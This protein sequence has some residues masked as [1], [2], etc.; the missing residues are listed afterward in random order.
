MTALSSS[1]APLDNDDVEPLGLSLLELEEEETTNHIIGDLTIQGGLYLD[2]NRLSS[3]PEGFG[4]LTIGGELYLH[5]NPIADSLRTDSF[6]GIRL[7]L[8]RGW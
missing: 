4:S 5:H 2:K 6:D 1:R 8:G 3:L 7:V